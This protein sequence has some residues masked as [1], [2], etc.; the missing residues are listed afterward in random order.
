MLSAYVDESEQEE[1]GVFAV[2]GFVFTPAGADRFR[3]RW[4]RALKSARPPLQR[5]HMSEYESGI[6]DYAN[7]PEH[8]RQDFLGRLI[9]IIRS[10]A[11][12]GVSVAVDLRAFNDLPR[13]EREVLLDSTPYS[14]TVAYLVA[15]A[16]RQLDESED[17]AYILDRAP[18]NKGQTRIDEE[19]RYLSRR[20]QFPS[21][22]HFNLDT[23]TWANSTKVS[24]LQAAD[25]FAYEC[26]KFIV[27]E[28]GRVKL[29]HRKSA[30]LLLSGTHGATMLHKTIDATELSELVERIRNGGGLLATRRNNSG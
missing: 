1:D 3:D 6:K 13:P 29:E 26:A 24:P 2:A 21:F 18:K 10:T 15:I 11:T 5:F 22:A 25:I 28:L 16:A 7:W 14:L 17:V 20:Q 23:L 30:R 12:M 4:A 19:F 27:R 9:R 8:Y